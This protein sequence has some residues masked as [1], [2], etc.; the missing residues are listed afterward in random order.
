MHFDRWLQTETPVTL[1]FIQQ[2]CETQVTEKSMGVSK[3]LAVE[4]KC[5]LVE[6]CEECKIIMWVVLNS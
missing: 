1:L 5:S 4:L 2:S 3:L 6:Y